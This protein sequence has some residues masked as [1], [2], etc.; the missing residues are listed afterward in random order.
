[1][2]VYPKVLGLNRYKNHTLTFL[3]GCCCCCSF[4]SSPILSLSSGSSICH[5]WKWHFGIMC[6]TDSNCSWILG[7]SWQQHPYICNFI[8]QNKKHSKG[9]K[10]RNKE[11]WR[12]SPQQCFGGQKLLLWQ[13]SVEKHTVLIKQPVLVLPLFCILLADL[14][15]QMLPNPQAVM[16]VHHLGTRNE[17][18]MNSVLKVKNNTNMQMSD[19]TCLTFFGCGEEGFS[20]NRITV[21]FLGR[22]SKTR[23][24]LLCFWCSFWKFEAK[25]NANA[26]FLQIS[27]YTMVNHT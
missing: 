6:G 8:L 4:Q 12:P 23:F 17:F 1:M 15:P 11:D 25:L 19:L 27:H 16:L 24:C 22:N 20:S 26:L 7:T 14:L 2:G 5:C 3:T 18:L 9:T 13:S 21:L 10:S